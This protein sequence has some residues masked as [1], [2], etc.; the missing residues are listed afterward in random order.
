MKFILL[1]TNNQDDNITFIRRVSGTP[2]VKRTYFDLLSRLLR[3]KKK[4]AKVI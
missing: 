4:R 3:K 2:G 1:R